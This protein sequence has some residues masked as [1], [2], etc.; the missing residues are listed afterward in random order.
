MNNSP[1]SQRIQNLMGRLSP[2]YRFF[3]DSA[4][5]RRGNGPGVND[6]AVGNPQEMALEGFAETLQRW[7]VPQHKD[8]YAYTE[9]E[10]D[11]RAAVVQ[12]LQAQRGVSYAPE[13]IHLTNGAFAALAVALTA[14]GRPAQAQ[15][16]RA[17]AQAVVKHMADSLADPG[18]RE[19]FQQQAWL[20][21]A[22]KD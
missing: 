22:E 2:V 16:Q 17:A 12:A 1:S 18:W 5:A 9:S 14:L 20:M 15:A 6:F 11:A 8:W 19:H 3:T 10:P 4:Y 21:I 13:D 7:A